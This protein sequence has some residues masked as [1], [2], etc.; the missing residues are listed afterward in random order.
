MA[1][2]NKNMTK[3]IYLYVSH[4]VMILVPGSYNEGLPNHYS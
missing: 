1:K 3:Q 2:N 4:Q